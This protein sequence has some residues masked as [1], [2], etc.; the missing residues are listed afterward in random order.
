MRTG[1]PPY[2]GDADVTGGGPADTVICWKVPIRMKS[3]VFLFG[4]SPTLEFTCTDGRMRI[5]W[6]SEDLVT[7]EEEICTGTPNDRIREILKKY[8][9]PRLEGFPPFTGG[10]R[11]IFLMTT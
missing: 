9:S 7:G 4:S 2:R 8:K 6:L 3:A 10:R 5:R 1:I 11:D